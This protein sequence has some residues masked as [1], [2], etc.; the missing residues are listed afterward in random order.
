MFFHYTKINNGTIVCKFGIFFF[1]FVNYI[2][3]HIV[4]KREANFFSAAAKNNA[5]AGQIIGHFVVLKDF[6]DLFLCLVI[7]VRHFE[8]LISR[9]SGQLSVFFDVKQNI[10]RWLTAKRKN[11]LSQLFLE[12]QPTAP[13]AKNNSTFWQ[14]QIAF[15][16]TL[17]Q[18]IHHG[19]PEVR[20]VFKFWFLYFFQF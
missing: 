7:L 20:I 4:E 10:R 17:H 14:I 11:K 19:G 5:A 8:T 13:P 16:C 1:F 18:K 9:S 2:C 6:T 12:Q 3:E 15:L